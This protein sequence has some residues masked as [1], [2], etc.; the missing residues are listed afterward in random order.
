V[1]GWLSFC[2]HGFR[3]FL[4]ESCDPR[5]ASLFRIGY[6]VLLL[7]Y[8]G[9]WL[10]DYPRWFTEE[11]I[12]SRDAAA[13]LYAGRYPSVL[14]H[15]DFSSTFVATCLWILLGQSVLLL[16]GCWSRFQIA[17]I[18]LW[19]VTFHHRNVLIVDGEDT[20]FRLFAFWM[21]WMPLDYAWSFT[22]W[23]K[24]EW[25]SARSAPSEKDVADAW[26]L[27][28]IHVQV[29][30]I[31]ASA[32]VSKLGGETWWDGTAMYYVWNMQDLGGRLSLTEAWLDWPWLVRLA[33][34]SSLAVE[35]FLPF[36]LW[37]RRTR[38]LAVVLG[39]ALHLAIELTMNLFLFEWIMILGLLGFLDYPGSGRKP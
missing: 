1:I 38:W 4:F 17:C 3:R 29:T 13:N 39:V 15:F 10:S 23:R 14:N 19:L 25:L 27:R 34:W 9:A 6:S 12:F 16:L 26:G 24:G 30:L 22:S 5:I 20:V 21:I 37:W 28:L 35:I 31:Y 11:G 36:G 2:K 8:V 32:A 18:F 33:T 7:V